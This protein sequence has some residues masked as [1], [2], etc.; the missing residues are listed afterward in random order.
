VGVSPVLRIFAELVPSPPDA[1]DYSTGEG[2]KE[3]ADI[4]LSQSVHQRQGQLLRGSDKS[5]YQFTNDE[6]NSD[7]GERSRTAPAHNRIAVGFGGRAA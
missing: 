2:Y 4:D 6:P 7:A 5:P 1:E 3:N